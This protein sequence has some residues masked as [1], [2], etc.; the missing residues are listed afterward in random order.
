MKRFAV[1][2]ASICLTTSAMAQDLDFVTDKKLCPMERFDRQEQGM[3]FDGKGFY[4]IEYHCE[5]AQAVSRS[6][7]DGI[8]TVVR[9]GY[10]EEPGALFPTVFAMRWMQ[11]DVDENAR[12]LWVYEGSSGEPTTYYDCSG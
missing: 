6:D 4:E 11:I 5:L 10:C 12:V 8:D 2:F 9:P 3:T 7:L 1:I